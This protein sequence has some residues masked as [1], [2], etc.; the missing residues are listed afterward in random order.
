MPH[1]NLIIAFSA[2]IGVTLLGAVGYELIEGWSF[3]DGLYMT[4][5]TI[6][7][8]GYSET[9][10]LSH[11]GRGYTIVL[12]MVGTLVLLY[13]ASLLT[14]FIV[15]G[16]LTDIL[17]RRKMK[18][19]IDAMSGHYLVCGNSDTGKY[20]VEELRKIRSNFVV[21]ER[22]PTHIS[23]LIQHGVAYIEGDAT[24]EEVLREAGIERAHGL[25]T[26]LHSDADNLFV[27]L[28]AKS[29]NQNLRVIAKAVNEE[30]RAKFLRVGADSV[31]MP[32]A[33]GGLRMVS[34]MIRPS[35]VTFLDTML[36][37][38]DQTVRLEEV[39]LPQNSSVV[40]QLLGDTGILSR[41]GASLV[42]LVRANQ[43]YHFNPPS[44]LRLEAG[45]VLILMGLSSVIA[46]LDSRLNTA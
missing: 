45:D 36:R 18:K 33:I 15:E 37:D 42:A 27:A 44:S 4:V 40:G 8:V 28:T 7:S 26:T 34:E 30:S 10:E 6:A 9:H 16:T 11:I 35:V 14:A 46:E 21:I 20:I 19:I 43:P 29:M 25:I 41:E 13:C 32:N 2:L 22:D 39:H 24:S 3:F 31:V 17:K 38:K 5:I 12:I 23:D 1:K